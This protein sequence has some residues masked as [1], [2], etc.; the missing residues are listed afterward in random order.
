MKKKIKITCNNFY[1]HNYAYYIWSKYVSEYWSCN[2]VNGHISHLVF[3]AS[4]CGNDYSNNLP[5]HY[6]VYPG[7]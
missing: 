6:T 2:K 1:I 4:S 5:G 7:R 3:Q